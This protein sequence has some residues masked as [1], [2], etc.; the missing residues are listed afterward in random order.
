MTSI[1]M[2]SE[3][4]LIF[5]LFHLLWMS[6]HCLLT[7]SLLSSFS[8]YVLYLKFEIYSFNNDGNSLSL[9]SALVFVISLH[10]H[11]STSS[12]SLL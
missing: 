11:F 5:Y 7:L 12:G 9:V 2:R 6:F 8:V 3:G 10:Y 1:A 4:Y